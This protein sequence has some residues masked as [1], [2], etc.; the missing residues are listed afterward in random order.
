MLTSTMLLK[1]ITEKKKEKKEKQVT[2]RDLFGNK[3]RKNKIV[4]KKRKNKSKY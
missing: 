2:Y 4:K 3:K 1:A